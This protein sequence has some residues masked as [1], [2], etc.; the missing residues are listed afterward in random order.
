MMLAKNAVINITL[1][2]YVEDYKLHLVFS[3]NEERIVDFEPFLQKSS[4]PMIR[5]Y[6][7]LENFKHFT[8]KYGDLFWNDYDLCFPI[9]NL[10]DGRI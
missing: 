8:V 2:E 9:A 10:Y 5:K 6:L 7:E 1:V 3:D 4:N